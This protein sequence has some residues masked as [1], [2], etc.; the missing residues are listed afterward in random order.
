MLVKV[1]S[2]PR[3]EGCRVKGYEG[4]MGLTII[5]YSYPQ[6]VRSAGYCFQNTIQGLHMKVLDVGVLGPVLGGKGWVESPQ[7]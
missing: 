4:P 2:K 3:G 1:L 7:R 5:I 6:V